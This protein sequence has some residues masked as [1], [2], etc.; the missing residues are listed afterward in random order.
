MRS[1]EEIANSFLP[2]AETGLDTALEQLCHSYRKAFIVAVRI[3]QRDALGA[4]VQVC[5]AVR[6]EAV[7][8]SGGALD[9][10]NA[11]R[12]LLATR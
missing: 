9:C 2:E 10:A 7:I 4:A 1:P 12:S 8:P 11:I 3:A 6:G 5:E